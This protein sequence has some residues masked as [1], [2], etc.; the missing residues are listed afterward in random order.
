MR[1]TYSW[2]RFDVTIEVLA[3][4]DLRIVERQRLHFSGRLFAYPINAMRGCA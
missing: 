1:P 3:N 2:E 4:G